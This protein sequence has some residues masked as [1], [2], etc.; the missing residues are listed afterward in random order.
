M[1]AIGPNGSMHCGMPANGWSRQPWTGQAVQP[2]YEVRPCGNV[3]DMHRPE[4]V[5][6]HVPHITAS[7]AAHRPT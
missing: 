2:L 4:Q 3:F 1:S 7:D 5:L 6:M